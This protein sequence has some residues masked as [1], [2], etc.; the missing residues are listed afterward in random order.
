MLARLGGTQRRFIPDEEDVEAF[1]GIQVQDLTNEL[2]AQ[3]GYEGESG[4]IVAAVERRSV[5]A[6]AQ[7]SVGTLIQ[8]I[9]G[10]E[11]SNLKDYREQIE[12]VKD[13][14]KILLYVRQPNNRGCCICHT[15]K[16]R[17]TK[18]NR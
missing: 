7:I 4:V 11:I 5:A 8:E 9:E 2:A 12:V 18:R 14:A 1:A 6:R 15:G 10:M 16:T 13:Q 3:Y 17:R